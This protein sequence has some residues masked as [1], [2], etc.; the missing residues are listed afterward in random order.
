MSKMFVMSHLNRI[1]DAYIE[2]NILGKSHKNILCE[3][4]VKKVP[5]KYY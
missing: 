4:H 2:C 1:D 5:F 3:V